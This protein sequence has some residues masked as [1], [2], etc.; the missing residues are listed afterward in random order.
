MPPT[1][2]AG[3]EHNVKTVADKELQ[4]YQSAL[5]GGSDTVRTGL[6]MIPAFYYRDYKLLREI[7]LDGVTT[8]VE[9]KKITKTLQTHEQR[10]SFPTGTLLPLARL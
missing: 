8:P 5:F 1:L 6:R 10:G 9:I 3:T 2:T 4:F 7:Y